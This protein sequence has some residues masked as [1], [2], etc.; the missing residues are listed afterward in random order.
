MINN[1]VDFFVLTLGKGTS[2]DGNTAR[3]FFKNSQKSADITG[4]DKNLIQRFGNILSAM[5]SGYEV[6]IPKFELYT[7]DT[8]KLFIFL[9]P[10]YYMPS[11]VHKILIHGADVINAALLPIG[12]I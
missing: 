1:P 2:N 9:Y 5:A 11:S 7:K 8:A 4:V 12:K 10:W 3:R 6:N